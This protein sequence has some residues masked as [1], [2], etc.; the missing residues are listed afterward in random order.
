[1]S[2]VK[3]EETVTAPKAVKVVKEGVAKK[4]TKAPKAKGTATKS[5][6]APAKPA[7]GPKGPKMDKAEVKPVGRPKG[8]VK[9]EVK[10]IEVF[11]SFP[12]DRPNSVAPIGGLRRVVIEAGPDGCKQL[13][14]LAK[15]I[16]RNDKKL[17]D[18]L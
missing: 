9:R 10:G 8:S 18:I 12:F 7:G 6:K 14:K 2:V 13:E 5:T 16:E 4:A 11:K 1:M 17:R 3:K 15:L